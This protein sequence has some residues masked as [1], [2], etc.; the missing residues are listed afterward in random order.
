MT[1][2]STGYTRSRLEQLDAADPMSR[3]RLKFQPCDPGRVALDANS[4]GPMPGDVPARIDRILKQGWHGL[5]RRGWSEA[6]WLDKPARL[7]AAV[8]HLIGAGAD[9]VLVC[10]NTTVNLFKLLGHAWRARRQGF[11]ILTEAA[12][13]PTDLHVA[14]GFARLIS[15]AGGQAELVRAPS[16]EAV[17]QRL[18]SA[19]PD[20][21]VV[22]LTHTDF[23]D[24]SAWDLATTTAA[25]HASGALMLWDLSHSAG[26]VDIDLL[27]A[28]AD[29]AVAC[30]YKYLC[31]GPGGPSLAFVHPRHREVAPILQGWMG[32]VGQPGFSPDYQPAPGV[33]RLATGTPSV[34]ANEVFAAAA[35]IWKQVD[36][37]EL[38]ARHRALGDV[39]IGLLDQQCAGL[40]V[41]VLSPRDAAQRGGH[42]A[43]SH[44]GA[45][46]I[47]QALLARNVTLS[48]RSPNA[49][50]AGIS[51]L[52]HNRVDLWDAIAVLRDVLVSGEWRRPE[53]SKLSI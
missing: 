16:R 47:V 39:M 28:G 22:M 3:W 4:I 7:G 36:R 6:D 49:V 30:G 40:G 32:H 23:R 13:F 43:F 27:G 11:R 15:E 29:F 37:A 53:Y 10:D 25:A 46:P 38:A 8:A 18:A 33:L 52:Y 42:V 5:G 41:S 35:D 17:L 50:R 1:A 34:V 24:G 51:P 21:A 2:E 14:D 20:I 31:G 48:F 44:E 12:N 45:G 9:D 26:A 19:D